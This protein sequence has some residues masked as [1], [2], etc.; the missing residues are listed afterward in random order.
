MFVCDYSRRLAVYSCHNG[1]YQLSVAF[2]R[3]S[4]FPLKIL[5]VMC[6]TLARC[7]KEH[8]LTRTAFS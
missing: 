7:L 4:V 5:S 2:V 3:Y 1:T 6:Y 8:F